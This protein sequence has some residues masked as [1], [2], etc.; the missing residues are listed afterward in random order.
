[1]QLYMEKGKIDFA[2]V[3]MLGI[4]IWAD[5]QGKFKWVLNSIKY[6]LRRYGREKFHTS[7]FLLQRQKLE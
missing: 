4:V 3:T 6:T 7:L 5:Y 2:E 1:M